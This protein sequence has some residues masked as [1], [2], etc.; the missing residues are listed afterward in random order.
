MFRN[1]I[2]FTVSRFC[3]AS[4]MLYFLCQSKANIMAVTTPRGRHQMVPP[5]LTRRLIINHQAVECTGSFLSKQCRSF[6]RIQLTF[7][8]H[9]YFEENCTREKR[10]E[11]TTKAEFFSCVRLISK[12]SEEAYFI[13]D[14]LKVFINGK[15]FNKGKPYFI[16]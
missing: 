5:P 2:F 4:C 14:N 15:I 8:K 3:I 7:S 9:K 10:N 1:R 12:D 6:I 13:V 16:Y 11:I